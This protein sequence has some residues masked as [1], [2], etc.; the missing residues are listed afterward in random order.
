MA[1]KIKEREWFSFSDRAPTKR[2]ADKQGRVLWRL[3]G[4]GYEI[5]AAIDSRSVSEDVLWQWSPLSRKKSNSR[6]GQRSLEWCRA[7][8]WEVQNYEPGRKAKNAVVR[9][10]NNTSRASR[11]L[12]IKRSPRSA[13]AKAVKIDFPTPGPSSS[14]PEKPRIATCR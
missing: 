5:K 8:G 6:T 1:K 9:S 12:T 7:Q 13:F 14:Q 2:D 3:V 10:S 4:D 11:K